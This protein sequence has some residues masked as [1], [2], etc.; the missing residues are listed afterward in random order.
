VKAIK[1]ISKAHPCSLSHIREYIRETARETDDCDS[2]SEIQ[3][4]GMDRA[5]LRKDKEAAIEK[6]IGQKWKEK[7][8]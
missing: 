8:A 7:S 3:F 5:N 1:R 4:S 2:H 6:R